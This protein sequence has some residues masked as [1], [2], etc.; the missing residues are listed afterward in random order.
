MTE[1]KPEPGDLHDPELG[2]PGDAEPL[3]DDD[4]EDFPTEVNDDEIDIEDED[5]DY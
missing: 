1:N 5:E 4:H 3:P 2:L